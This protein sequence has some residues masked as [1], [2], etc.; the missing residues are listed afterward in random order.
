MNVTGLVPLASAMSVSRPISGEAARSRTRSGPP[1]TSRRRADAV[2]A[3]EPSDRLDDGVDA[4]ARH[5]AAELQDDELARVEPEPSGARHPCAWANS[6]RVEAARHDRDPA[7]VG[8]VQP[9][10]VVLVLRALG[11]RRGR[12]RRRPS[13]RCPRARG[14][15]VGGALVQPTDLAERVEGDD[16]RHAERP[17]DLARPARHEEVGVDDVVPRPREVQSAPSSAGT[18]ACAEQ[19]FLRDRLRWPGR[20]V[21]HPDARSAFHRHLEGP[22]RRDGCRRPPRRRRRR[23]AARPARRTRSARRRRRR[24]ARPAERRAR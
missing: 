3:L 18:R 16:E 4:L 2:D 17:L 19:P 23:D 5:H 21:D 8:A 12:P 13:P 7:R 15:R 24:P 10:E 6:V 9:D 20:D 11:D 22:G 14:E 1:T